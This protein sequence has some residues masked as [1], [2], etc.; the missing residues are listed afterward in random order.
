MHCEK[1]I[2]DFEVR[3]EEERA[4]LEKELIDS[5]FLDYFPEGARVVA[6]LE[7]EDGT[8]SEYTV[9]SEDDCLCSTPSPSPHLL[10]SL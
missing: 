4:R 2:I 7:D 10:E 1:E 8:S 6:Y 3:H 9:V 5:G